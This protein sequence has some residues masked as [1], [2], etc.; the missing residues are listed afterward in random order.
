MHLIE[1]VL[2][3]IPMHEVLCSVVAACLQGMYWRLIGS[4]IHRAKQEKGNVCNTLRRDT[5]K[6]HPG[7]PGPGGD[8]HDDLMVIFHL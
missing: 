2:D 1:N 7:C 3:L 4:T 5:V 6:L 8:E